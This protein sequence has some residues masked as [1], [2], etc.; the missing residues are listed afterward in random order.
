MSSKLGKHD[1]HGMRLNHSFV[2]EKHNTAGSY[3]SHCQLS[4]IIGELDHG[5]TI[6]PTLFPDNPSWLTRHL[7]W[8]AQMSHEKSH[9]WNTSQLDWE[10]RLTKHI[11]RI[12]SNILP[13]CRILILIHCFVCW[14]MVPVCFAKNTVWKLTVFS[15]GPCACLAKTARALWAFI[16]GHEMSAVENVCAE[17]AQTL[18]YNLF[19]NTFCIQRQ[20][21]L[22]QNV[23]TQKQEDW[24][25]QR[26]N[27]MN[28]TRTQKEWTW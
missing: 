15:S 11:N 9:V 26:S 18:H 22:W 25:G 17:H 2:K 4:Q 13:F 27:K 3:M 5:Y 19:C 14:Y 12:N 24:L 6:L 10:N 21:W 23:R 20:R 8:L 16:Q 7:K 1:L 28:I